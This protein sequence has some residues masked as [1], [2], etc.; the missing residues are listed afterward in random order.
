MD[1]YLHV[2]LH[3]LVKLTILFLVVVSCIFVT[4]ERSTVVL[5]FLFEVCRLYGGFFTSPEQLTAFPDW[6]FA[7]AI[8]FIKYAFV[9]VALNQLEDLEFTCTAKQV[10]AKTCIQTG[11]KI[12]MTK[13][14]DEY[15]ISWLAGMLVAYI[16]IV[17][18]VGYIALRFVKS[19]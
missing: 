5:S 7:D 11:E 17:R 18:V 4:V 12:I 13:G 16:I 9:G 2:T 6:Q 1:L 15:S 14:Y 10:A 8:S 3:R 19:G